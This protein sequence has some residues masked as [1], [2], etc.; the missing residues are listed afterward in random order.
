MKE[1]IRRLKMRKAASK[2]KSRSVDPIKAY[3]AKIE[4][5]I[6]TW[7]LDLVIKELEAEQAASDAAQTVQTV[8][9]APV[10]TARQVHADSCGCAPIG[11]QAA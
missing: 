5:R 2:K 9:T 4:V 3:R 6:Y 8:Q 10:A 11:V 7:L 1:I